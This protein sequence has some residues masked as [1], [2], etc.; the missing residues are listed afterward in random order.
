MDC[1]ASSRGHAVKQAN[2]PRFVIWPIV[3]MMIMM[4]MSFGALSLMGKRGHVSLYE[5][6]H[7][8]EKYSA[9]FIA[10]YHI[11]SPASTL[12]S[13]ITIT[14]AI[15]IAIAIL[16]VTIPYM[17]EPNNGSDRR[18]SQESAGIR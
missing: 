13:A 6:S 8:E 1:L 14:I 2:L 7:I 11:V 12:C 16:S 17:G 3:M 4:A 15:T 5:M 18:L 9:D 10:Y